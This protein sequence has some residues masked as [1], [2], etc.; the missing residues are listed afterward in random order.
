[1]TN[2]LVFGSLLAF[3]TT[4]EEAESPLS[5]PTGMF[6]AYC[7]AV[8]FVIGCL[9]TVCFGDVYPKALQTR[10]FTLLV[11][12]ASTYLNLYILTAGLAPALRENK[13]KVQAARELT[14][15]EVDPGEGGLIRTGF[16]AS[17]PPPRRL[18]LERPTTI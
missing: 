18:T 4:P 8:Y 11:M 15:G 1:M 14:E 13:V 9:T 17:P 2:L 10:M 6:H 3:R 16:F 12:M 5:K 7:M